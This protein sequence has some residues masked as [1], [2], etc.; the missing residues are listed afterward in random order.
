ME[1]EA[2]IVYNVWVEGGRDGENEQSEK[3]EEKK[4]SRPNLI[5][6]SYIFRNGEMGNVGRH[7][8]VVCVSPPHAC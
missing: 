6:V 1:G 2:P 3:K 5:I 4:R 8:V 7:S